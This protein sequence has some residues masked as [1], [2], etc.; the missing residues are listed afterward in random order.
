[1]ARHRGGQHIEPGQPTPL[2]NVHL[3]ILDKVGIDTEVVRRQ[4]RA[5]IAESD[6]DR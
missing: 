5:S 2:A 6:A 1:M 4:H 3:T